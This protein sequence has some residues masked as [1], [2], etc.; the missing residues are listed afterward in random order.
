[1]TDPRWHDADPRPPYGGVPGPGSRPS[2][3]GPN[4]GPRP[5][6]PDYRPRRR[7]PEP[8]PGRDDPD[9]WRSW[10]A[11]DKWPSRR[12]P[13][14][15]PSRND[16]PPDPPLYDPA[17][18][19]SI[20]DPYDRPRSGRD[21]RNRPGS[22]QRNRPGRGGSGYD[23]DGRPARRDPGEGRPSRRREPPA[24]RGLPG[25]AGAGIVLGAAVLGAIVTVVA[26]KDP[27]NL[28]GAFL[29][30]GTIGAAFGVR[31]RSAYLLVPA[32]AL[33]Y[34]LTAVAA[35]LVHDHTGGSLSALT[36]SGTQWI[37][38]GFLT[39][40]AATVAALVI[41]VA[42]WYRNRGGPGSTKPPTDP[43]PRGLS[44]TGSRGI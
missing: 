19:P 7:T 43:A 34:V 32:P 12:E 14:F 29:V 26:R 18:E 35:G 9:P 23:P 31:A 5:R 21:E 28:L 1:M 36:A 15:R 13:N 27:G 20:Y 30:V 22:G 11:P 38:G 24:D 3:R 16:P 2:R 44:G 10:H 37:A 6:D 41:A 40:A 25:L 33:A 39:M 8:Q 42:R 17:S 4:P